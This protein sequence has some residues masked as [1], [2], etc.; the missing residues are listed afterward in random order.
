[1]NKIDR[2][3]AAVEGRVPDRV[4]YTFWSHFPEIDRDPEL[5]TQATVQLVDDYD[6]DLVKVMSNGMYAV[7][8][9]GCECDFS[10][11]SRGGVAKIVKTPVVSVDDW[12]KIAELSLDSPALR[13]E[14]ETLGRIL[15]KLK[16]RIPVLFTVFSP[17]TI[18][19][20]LSCGALCGH[21][22]SG[23]GTAV[24]RALG[25]MAETVRALSEKALETGADGVF[26]ATQS[27]VRERFSAEE[28]AEYGVP[29]DLKALE[30]ASKGW[31]NT[32]HLHGSD[33]H[34][35]K[36]VDYPVQILNWH[37]WET[38]PD[39]GEAAKK[40]SKCLMGGLKRF[41]ITENRKDE[42]SVQIRDSLSQSGGMRHIL[43][44]G[45]VI[46][47]PIPPDALR[48]IRET[49]RTAGC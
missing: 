31:C 37:V 36:C 5:L 15:E 26:F 21:L 14:I 12:S 35:D 4:P 20:K 7:E 3:R 13:R 25:A 47:L 8:D 1:M 38:A 18:A 32:V 43:S 19:E 30:G 48:H 29:Y 22:D 24:H 45:C 9:F 34:F 41:S 11:V 42:L 33:I 49:A 40:T 23:G 10:E 17:L 6:I 2:I 39:I 16:G 27:A 46:R 44:P 28:Y